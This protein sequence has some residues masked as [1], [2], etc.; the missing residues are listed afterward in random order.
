M[1]R[2]KQRYF[3][4]GKEEWAK[5]VKDP[6]SEPLIRLMNTGEEVRPFASEAE[7]DA[8]LA[9][10]AKAEAAALAR[11][12]QKAVQVMS[13]LAAMAAQAAEAAAE[14]E[15]V[16]SRSRSVKKG[17]KIPKASD[18]VQVGFGTVSPAPGPAPGAAADVEPEVAPEDNP[19][20]L[21][22]KRPP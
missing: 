14:G 5:V 21:A 17:S 10:L 4:R 12:A 11:Q 16:A 19:L 18:A 1:E 7:R 2:F 13:G 8:N 9:A 15:R 22:V 6:A 20:R 3:K